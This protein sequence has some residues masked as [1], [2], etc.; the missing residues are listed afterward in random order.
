MHHKGINQGVIGATARNYLLAFL[1]DHQKSIYTYMCVDIY[2]CIHIYNI[3]MYIYSYT[4]TY[5]LYFIYI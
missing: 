4:Y 2:V 5:V 1:H 3:Y